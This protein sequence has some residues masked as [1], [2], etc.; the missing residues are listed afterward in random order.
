M[1]K[2]NHDPVKAAAAAAFKKK[3]LKMTGVTT[4][5]Q[6]GKD[7]EKI[8]KVVKKGLI[9]EERREIYQQKVMGTYKSGFRFH[10]CEDAKV[11]DLFFVNKKFPMN[12]NYSL[13]YNLHAGSP[14]LFMGI[15]ELD[16]QT[17]QEKD[18]IYIL[19]GF[20]KI[21]FRSNWLKTKKGPEC[22][23]DDNDV[24]ST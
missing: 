17:G 1:A 7:Y 4:P 5:V 11:G 2:N 6:D 15:A 13:V 8:K 22:N 18:W 3:E 9:R 19:I 10:I 14:V 23:L 12:H 16:K 24:E 21:L 20:N